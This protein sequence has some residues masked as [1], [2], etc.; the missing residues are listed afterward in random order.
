MCVCGVCVFYLSSS[1]PEFFYHIYFLIIVNAEDTNL[2]DTSVN[3]LKDL[4]Y[5]VFIHLGD[6]GKL[7]NVN[8]VIV[9]SATFSKSCY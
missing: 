6:L 4:M 3:H 7:S 1:S 2:S 8:L 5:K 9:G